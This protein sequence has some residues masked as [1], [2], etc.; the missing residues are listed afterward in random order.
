MKEYIVR[1]V[2]L[3][4]F[5]IPYFRVFVLLG[6]M[7]L[8]GFVLLILW[9]DECALEPCKNGGTCFDTGNEYFC[10]CLEGFKGNE[11]EIDVSN[12]SKS[13]VVTKNTDSRSGAFCSKDICQNNGTCYE[14]ENMYYCK[15]MIGFEG[16][17]CEKRK[18]IFLFIF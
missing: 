8:S 11:C 15:C 1:N 18:F 6:S 16:V 14:N 17:H 12:Q 4:F 3:Y 10:V 9:E 2:S 5:K 7:F 13:A